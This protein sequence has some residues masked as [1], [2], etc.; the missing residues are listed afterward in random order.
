M[1]NILFDLVNWFSMQCDGSWEHGEGITIETL[2]NPGW[3]IKVSLDGTLLQDKSFVPIK[4]GNPDDEND[5]EWI[6]CYKQDDC[7]IAYGGR[8]MLEEIIRIFIDWMKENSDTSAWD[9]T[10]ERLMRD[11]RVLRADGKNGFVREKETRH[12]YY[13]ICDIPNEHP[14]K[15]ELMKTLDSILND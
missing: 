3:S 11:I 15:K 2:D 7:F 9:D 6:D 14:R 4:K 1:S 10:V 5:A 12:L 8:E 13:Q